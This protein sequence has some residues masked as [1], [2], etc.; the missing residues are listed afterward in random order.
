MKK[1]TLSAVII[2]ICISFC[3]LKAQYVLPNIL[4]Q[5][6]EILLKTDSIRLKKELDHMRFCFN[7]FANVHTAGTIMIG[8][9]AFITTIS[10]IQLEN[11]ENMI[12]GLYVGAGLSLIGWI[13][14]ESSFGWMKRASLKPADNGIGIKVNL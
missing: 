3:T 5:Y 11:N 9:G 6:P 12:Y 1:I 8:A 4:E 2:T 10:A 14:E 13:V 7:K